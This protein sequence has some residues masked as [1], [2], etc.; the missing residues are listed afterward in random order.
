MKKSLS[1]DTSVNNVLQVFTPS[2]ISWLSPNVLLLPFP[3]SS[4]SNSN[5]ALLSFFRF[6]LSHF[7]LNL[8]LTF[9]PYLYFSLIHAYTHTHSCSHPLWI[10]C[11]TSNSNCNIC[12]I[13]EINFVANKKYESEKKVL[14]FCNINKSIIVL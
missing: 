6:D 7:L 8:I 11:N 3:H 13:N 1:S 5:L 2:A 9:F 4:L 14:I 10:Y 12:A